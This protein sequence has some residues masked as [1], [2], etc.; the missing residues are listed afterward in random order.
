MRHLLSA[1][2]FRQLIAVSTLVLGLAAC[3]DSTGPGEAEPE[4]ATMRIT[5]ASG[6]S[7]TVNASGTVSGSLTIPAGTATGFTVEFL[8]ASGAPDPLVTAA[9]FRASVTPATGIT[10][11]RSGNFEG[12]LRGDAAGTVTVRFGLLHIKENHNDFGPFPVPVTVTGAI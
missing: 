1:P 12:T 8:G 9:E 5:L 11:T 10:F 7:A 4:V 3:K 2:R 6:A